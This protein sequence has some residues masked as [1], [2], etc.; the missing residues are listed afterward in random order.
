MFIDNTALV[1]NDAQQRNFQK[2]NILGT[3]V[4]PNYYVGNSYGEE[5]QFLKTWI[6]GRLSWMDLNMPGNCY[7]QP[8]F[9]LD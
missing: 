6:S 7:Q 1:L 8:L 3:Y 5:I 4:W 9:V 2:W